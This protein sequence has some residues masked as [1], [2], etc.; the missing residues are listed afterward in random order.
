[1]PVTIL[2]SAHAEFRVTD[3]E[4]A[5]HFYVDTLGF[6][7]THETASALYLGGYEERD[8]YSLALR[9]ADAP[10]VSHIAFRVESEA[11]LDRLYEL[12]RRNELKTRWVEPDE[13]PGQGR[14]LRFQDP[15]GLPVE[16]FHEIRRRERAAPAVPQAPR[17]GRSAH[18]PFQ[19]PGHRC[20]EGF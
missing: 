17:R 8:L 7:L 18:R 19:L 1:M 5:R 12:A 2:R 14:A 16:C 13:E 4:A 15:N 20:A 6:L 3:L 10:G 11:D 9:K